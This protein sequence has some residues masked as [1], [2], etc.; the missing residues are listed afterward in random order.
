MS[1][2]SRCSCQDTTLVTDQKPSYSHCTLNT[3]NLKLIRLRYCM[4]Y[5]KITE[6]KGVPGIPLIAL[7]LEICKCTVFK[8]ND[9]IE[10]FSMVSNG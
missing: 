4:L 2:Q 10:P 1:D 8:H 7:N 9:I 3:S 5:K 6:I